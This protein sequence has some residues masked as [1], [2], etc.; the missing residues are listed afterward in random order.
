MVL[1]LI[2]GDAI[3]KKS[4][5]W[6]II[7]AAAVV[8]LFAGGLVWHKQPS[9]CATVCHR[10]MASY[11][12]SW[13]GG[14][15]LAATHAKAKLECLDCHEATLSQQMKE[16]IAFVTG[17]YTLPLPESRI[18]TKEFCLKC[19]GTYEELAEATEGYDA[20]GVNPHDSHYEDPD[21]Y[22]CHRMHTQS[23]LFCTK[24]HQGMKLPSG[25]KEAPM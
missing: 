10:P 20:G 2:R 14:N 1:E 3:V 11:Y 13:K 21:C 4:M 16:G 25:W 17:N 12:E 19:H 15:L 22:Q 24:C 6:F 23:T 18:G 7:A 8:L 9:F 5:I